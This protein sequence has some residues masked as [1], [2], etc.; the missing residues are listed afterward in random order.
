MAVWGF[1]APCK[2]PLT[3]QNLHTFVPSRYF[4]SLGEG[5]AYKKKTG[6]PLPP[7][8]DVLGWVMNGRPGV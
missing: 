8:K 7:V 2:L 4:S 5:R 1:W 3:P 6:G